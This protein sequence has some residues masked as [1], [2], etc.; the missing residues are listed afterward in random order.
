MHGKLGLPPDQQNRVLDF[1]F[2]DT[3]GAGM[4][5]LRNGIGSSVDSEKDFMMS[6][7]PV[8]P[9][10][11]S[12][13]PNYVWNGS[14]ESQVWLS[15]QAI[16]YGV[17][18]I[19]ADAWSAPG[20]MKTNGNDS[21]GGN[22]CGVPGTDCAT[23]DWR[24]AFANYLVQYLRLYRETGINITHLG[25]LNEPDLNQTYAAMQSSGIQAGDFLNVLSPTLQ[26]AGFSSVKL[27]CC[28]ATG[29]LQQEDILSE[30]Q[31]VPGAEDTLSVV[32]S[33]GYQTD[34]K[35]PFDTPHRVWQTE[36]ADLTG[37]WTDSWDFLGKVGEGISWANKIQQA[38]TLSNCSAFLYWI[39]AETTKTNSA[40]IRLN[41]TS[42]EVSSRLWAFGQF[43]R[44]VKP[45]ATR[46][47]TKSDIRVLHT[48]AFENA[49]G[50][51]AVQVINN[52]H[53]DYSVD[54]TI[55]GKSGGNGMTAMPWLTN[56]MNNLTNLEPISIMRDEETSK[57]RAVVPARSMVSFVM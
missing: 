51:I 33:H 40:L 12:S 49:N 31:T 14:D 32:S 48:S 7:E 9:G 34:P 42:V 1:L 17:R 37:A 28:D 50:T 16:G 56:N 47:G 41:G 26:A 38:L 27:V 15:Q 39:G 3:A 30:L 22:I 52:G 36:W 19:Y 5:I 55:A 13:P 35:L 2:S 46:I 25:F 6:I 54:L 24:Q 43:S 4:S 45:G 21:N 11:P 57:L 53:D 8:S 29:W 20:F 23:G 18:T 10:S 44:F